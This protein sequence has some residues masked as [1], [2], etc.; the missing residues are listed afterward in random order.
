MTLLNSLPDFTKES[1]KN[2]VMLDDYLA[3]FTHEPAKQLFFH[4]MLR[5]L[6]TILQVVTRLCSV[7][8]MTDD[9]RSHSVS[10]VIRSCLFA[11]KLA[12]TKK[13]H[14]YKFGNYQITTDLVE[15]HAQMLTSVRS[16]VLLKNDIYE[17]YEEIYSL[18][19][20]V[21]QLLLPSRCECEEPAV[22][23]NSAA[24]LLLTISSSIRPNYIL[25]NPFMLE[26]MQS[27]LTH[28]HDHNVKLLIKRIIFNCLLLPYSRIAINNADD[29]NYEKRGTILQQYV[30]F[31]S[32]KFLNLDGA[33]D[34]VTIREMTKTELKTYEELV[35]YSED[36]NTIT[37][38][39]LLASIKSIIDRSIELFQKYGKDQIMYE[40]IVNFYLS[41]IRVL[42]IQLG[43]QFVIQVIKMFLDTATASGGHL[44]P[45][46]MNVP[47]VDK[48]LQL[49][50]FI[51][52]QSGSGSTA[53]I[54][55][56]DILKITLDDMLPCERTQSV[57]ISVSLYSL[58]DAMLQNH[59]NY[60]QRAQNPSPATPPR[61][62]QEDLMRIFTAYGQFLV[63]GAN[64]SDPNVIRIILRSLEKLN[65]I[66]KL[67][68][69][70]FFKTYLLKSFLS[71]LIRL[72]ISPEGGLFYDQCLS[73]LFTMSEKNKPVLHD[74]FIS[75]GYPP[76]VK[77]IQQICETTD[78]PS[79]LQ[80]MDI[81]IIDTRFN[82]FL[83]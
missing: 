10:I 46:N 45:H 12:N 83:Q 4:C 43:S 73:I 16:L 52:Q 27:D 79:F 70:I 67:Y 17:N 36:T 78:Q 80:T 58:F 8:L 14:L 33:F 22:V 72:A 56:N 24:Q 1:G 62:H 75:I 7:V 11:L 9:S 26:L 69:K 32:H 50:L 71:T 25:K 54:L 40:C 65:E 49:L 60:F 61:N 2:P 3:V 23:V 55:M 39:M 77:I 31:V 81:L 5:D 42:Q 41:V 63:N 53:N 51:V 34:V 18:I 48:L 74:S 28:Q 64:N 19:D 21:T 37:K 68:D 20:S 76:D 47:A 59:W 82:Q 30:S 6:S 29:Q 35:M 38:Q 66:W 15:L 44:T 13:L 57:D